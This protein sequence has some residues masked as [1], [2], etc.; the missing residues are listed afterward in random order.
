MTWGNASE[1]WVLQ[2][3]LDEEIRKIE[4]TIGETV[5]PLHEPVRPFV[6]TGLYGEIPGADT[7]PICLFPSRP[8]NVM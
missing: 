8:H 1:Q 5:L 6:M 2:Q 4:L 7:S 3:R